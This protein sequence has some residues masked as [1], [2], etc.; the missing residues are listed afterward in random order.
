MRGRERA[1]KGKRKDQRLKL[2][3]GELM[4]GDLLQF[5]QQP[6]YVCACV[7]LCL[8]VCVCVCACVY[9]CVCVCVY[10]CV[11]LCDCN[12]MRVCVCVCVRVCVCLQICMCVCVCAPIMVLG[13]APDQ[14]LR[15]PLRR[16]DLKAEGGMLRVLSVCWSA[17]VCISRCA[18]ACVYV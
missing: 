9:V 17:Y 2:K 3:D 12:Y 1:Q 4:K 11:C 8:C 7:R 14:V 16:Y 13:L 15:D 18:C 5:V 6:V 10:V